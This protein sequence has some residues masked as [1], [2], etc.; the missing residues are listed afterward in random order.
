MRRPV[1]VN[2]TVEA[3]LV[4]A[5]IVPLTLKALQN[6]QSLESPGIWEIF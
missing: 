5:Q 1:R 3:T 4:E 2:T 6:T